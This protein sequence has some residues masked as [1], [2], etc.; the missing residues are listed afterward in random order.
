[1]KGLLLFLLL[2][3]FACFAQDF[4]RFKRIVHNNGSGITTVQ[5][6]HRDSHGYIWIGSSVNNLIRFDGTN[7]RYYDFTQFDTVHFRRS[8]GVFTFEDRK[9]NLWVGTD[10]GSL[11]KYDRLNDTFTLANDSVTSPHARIYSFAE[12]P[13]GSFWLGSL[14]GGL[15]HFHPETK[16]FKQ[17]KAEQGNSNSLPD[18]F[19]CGLG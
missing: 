15:I 12:A 4:P 2:S 17:Y 18:N 5:N 6:F 16:V 9:Q 13:D 19:I 3:S 10:V 1:M 8:R 14:G 7:F 11:F